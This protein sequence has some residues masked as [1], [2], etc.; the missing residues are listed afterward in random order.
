[1]TKIGFLSPNGEFIQ[2]AEQQHLQK[3]NELAMQ[4]GIQN[5]QNPEIELANLGWCFLQ[6][7]FAGIPAEIKPAPQFTDEQIQWI[8]DNYDSLNRQQHYFISEKLK[9]DEMYKKRNLPKGIDNVPFPG[10]L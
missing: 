4:L 6:R 10:L 1:M 9:F 8:L 7:H 3:A 2:C 5:S